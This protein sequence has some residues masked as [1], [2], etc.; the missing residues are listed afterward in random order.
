MTFTH[1]Y[2]AYN[3]THS[4]NAFIKNNLGVNAP[5][6]LNWSYGVSQ[7]RS[8]TFDWPDQPLHFP[9]FAVTHHSSV[10]AIS[11]EGDRA[12]GQYKGIIR[13]GLMEVNCWVSQLDEKTNEKNYQWAVQLQTMRDMVF[14]LFEKNRFISMY[15]YSN[16]A[17]PT[18]LK[19]LVRIKDMSEA[20]VMPDPNPAVRRV[21]ILITYRWVER[22]T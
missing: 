18:D 22:Y 14:L 2:G 13:Q 10:P 11:S 3:A 21:R 12:D 7:P 1:P 5:D 16:P 17:S 20:T 6:W 8:L 15:D 4:I 19:A 9:S